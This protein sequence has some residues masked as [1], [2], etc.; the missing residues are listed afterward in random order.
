M[1]AV[2]S[3]L[4]VHQW[5]LRSLNRT[6]RLAALCAWA[7]VVCCAGTAVCPA[8]TAG[9]GA[10]LQQVNSRR[11]HTRCWMRPTRSNLPVGDGTHSIR[12]LKVCRLAQLC[13]QLASRY[14]SGT[15]AQTRAMRLVRGVTGRMQLMRLRPPNWPP[16]LPSCCRLEASWLTWRR[17]SST[18]CSRCSCH[19]KATCEHE[20]AAWPPHWACAAHAGAETVHA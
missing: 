4:A 17:A 7:A 19:T 2:S 14:C 8:G 11:T 15:G 6:S 9:P 3:L 13:L 20:A 16:Q 18:R 1:S 10:L 5:H 12:S